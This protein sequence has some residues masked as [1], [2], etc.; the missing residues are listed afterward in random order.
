MGAHGADINGNNNYIYRIDSEEA[1]IQKFV[2]EEKSVNGSRRMGRFSLIHLVR[3]DSLMNL[4][5][6]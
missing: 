5:L 3:I 1:I 2:L 6:V 4:N